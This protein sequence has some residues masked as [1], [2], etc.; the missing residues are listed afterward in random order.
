[1]KGSR[2]G[3]KVM[4]NRGF[5][6]LEV[7]ITMVILS[8]GLLAL[9]GLMACTTRNNSFGGHMTE[10]AI[11]VQDKLEE[12]RATLWDIIPDG[13]RSDNSTS[14]TGIL[15]TRRW[16][17]VTNGNMKTVTLSVSW[18][19]RIDHSVSLVSVISR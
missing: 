13:T 3:G 6:L 11:L 15:F 2:S 1:M 7:L 17:V 12:L 10:G 14:S 18:N 8:V 4:R 5:T 9:A 16:T 19:D